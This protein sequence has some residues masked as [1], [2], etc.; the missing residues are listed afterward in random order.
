MRAA[1]SRESVAN[2]IR[3]QNAI[4]AYNTRRY[5]TIGKAAHTFEIPYSTMKDH[6]SG[7]SSQAQA[8]EIQQNLSNTKKKTLVQW[9]THLTI[10]EFPAYPKLVLKM[11]EKIRQERAFFAPQAS[12][13]PLGLH[14]VGHN[15]LTRFKQH[16][17]EISGI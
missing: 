1:K 11:A 7:A 14:P 15:W 10:T 2:E 9:I 13:G 12:P 6:L 4:A 5:C 17:P 16:N 3:I 8:R